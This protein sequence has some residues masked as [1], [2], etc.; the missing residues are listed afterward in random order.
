MVD[1]APYIIFAIAL[2]LIVLGVAFA[3][4]NFKRKKKTPVDYYALFVMGII[5]LVL[6]ILFDMAVFWILG[7][8]FAIFGILNKAK[9]KKNRRTWK[10]MDKFEKKVVITIIIILLIL[11]VIGALF[12]ILRDYGLM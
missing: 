12:F 1:M 2:V 7:L 3:V 9:W 4:I 11:V 10:D 5:W 8:V 6:G